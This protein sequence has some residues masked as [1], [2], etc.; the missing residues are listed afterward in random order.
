MRVILLA[1]SISMLAACSTNSSR[2]SEPIIEHNLIVKKIP[3]ELLEIPAAPVA[4]NINGSQKDIGLW[5]IE[6]E[7]RTKLLENQIRK[8]KEYNDGQ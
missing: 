2:P 8:I 3:S 6:S 5:I 7:K 4:A 1:L